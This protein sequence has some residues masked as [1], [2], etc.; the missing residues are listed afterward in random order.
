MVSAVLRPGATAT[1]LWEAIPGDFDLEKY[2]PRGGGGIGRISPG[3]DPPG[4]A[5]DPGPLP[6]GRKGISP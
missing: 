5:R 1:G 3:P 4:V 2:P 6:A